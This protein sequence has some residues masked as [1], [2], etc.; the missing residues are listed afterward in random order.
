MSNNVTQTDPNIKITKIYHP[1]FKRTSLVISD[2]FFVIF[3]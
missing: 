2:N 1:K 3:S